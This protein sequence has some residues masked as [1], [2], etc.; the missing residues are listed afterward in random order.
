MRNRVKFGWLVNNSNRVRFYAK[1]VLSGGK[2]IKKV[3]NTTMVDAM[4]WIE[5]QAQQSANRAA[6]VGGIW[7]DRKYTALAWTYSFND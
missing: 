3:F 5:S 6:F 7:Y 2:T 4:E 1:I